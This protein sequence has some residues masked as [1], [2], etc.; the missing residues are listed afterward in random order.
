MA[1][2]NAFAPAIVPGLLAPLFAITYAALAM[3]LLRRTDSRTLAKWIGVSI[4]LAVALSFTMSVALLPSALSALLSMSAGTLLLLW[5]AGGRQLSTTI[6]GAVTL[7][8]GAL[9]GFDP[10]VQLII[11]SSWIDLALFGAGAIVL[12]SILDRHGVAIKLRLARWYD[13]ANSDK[14]EIALD[15]QQ[16]S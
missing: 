14:K 7:G 3:D 15:S 1:L 5:G 11:T 13:N 12:G 10:L 8:A 16:L 6:A 4:S 9:L 2:T